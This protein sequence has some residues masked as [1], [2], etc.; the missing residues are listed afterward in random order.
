MTERMDHHPVPYA[1][2]ENMVGQ[3]QEHLDF[4]EA[5]VATLRGSIHK[6]NTWLG[7]HDMTQGEF[8]SLQDAVTFVGRAEPILEDAAAIMKADMR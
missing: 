7:A 1:D 6:I 4:I 2:A 8:R 3:L 5:Y